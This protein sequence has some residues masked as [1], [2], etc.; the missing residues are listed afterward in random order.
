[1]TKSVSQELRLIVSIFV[2]PVFM[3]LRPWE[4]D[5]QYVMGPA[6]MILPNILP[7]INSYNNCNITTHRSLPN[8]GQM[9]PQKG[10]VKF[11]YCTQ[12]TGKA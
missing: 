8:T 10:I 12:K 2:I 5:V 1:M 11:N 3:M 7:L 6:S 9:L 4:E